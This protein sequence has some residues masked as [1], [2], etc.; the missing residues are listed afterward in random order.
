MRKFYLMKPKSVLIIGMVWPEP[1]SSAAGSRMIQL[2]KL[3]SEHYEVIFACAAAKGP[4]SFDLSTLNVNTYEII[5]NDDSFN[6]LLKKLNPSIVVFDRFNMEEQYGWRVH[7]E[8]PDSLKILDTEDL[9]TLRDARHQGVK[10]GIRAEDADIYSEF[11]KREIASILRCDLSLIISPVEMDLLTGNYRIDPSLI[12]YLPFLEDKISETEYSNW[13]GFN[14]RTGFVFIGNFLHEPNWQ[15]AKYLKTTIWPLLSKKVPGAGCYIYGAYASQKV[16]QLDQ[17]KQNFFIRGRAEDAQETISRHRVMIAPLQFGAGLKGKFID[18]M[19]SGTPSVTTSIGA[20]GM[21]A[22]MTW[23]GAIADRPDDFAEYAALL[24][25]DQ[26]RW[27]KAQQTGMET[28]NTRYERQLFA[29][30]FIQ[31]IESLCFQL[32]L[33]RQHNFVGQILRHH[34]MNSL[35]YM[36]LWITEKNKQK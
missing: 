3:F 13:K 25:T 7:E 21:A 4:Y 16:L 26:S 27:E 12:C 6:K 11:A 10:K 18:A 9:H 34:T 22:A 5:L 14:E 15:A 33:H 8:C 1:S 2:I 31:K 36:S 19:R 29:D 35:K 23:P 28:I 24:Y 20:E 30:D 17:K 32:N